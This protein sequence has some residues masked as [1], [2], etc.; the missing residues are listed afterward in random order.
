M[1][2]RPSQKLLA[3][4]G[5]GEIVGRARAEGFGLEIKCKSEIANLAA[6]DC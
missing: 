2:V 5:Q 1:S 3:T 6:C 4:G